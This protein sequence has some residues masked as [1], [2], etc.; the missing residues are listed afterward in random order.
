VILSARDYRRYVAFT[1]GGL[2]IFGS[3]V[4]FT[5]QK[6]RSSPSVKPQPP[7]TASKPAGV[8]TSVRLAYDLKPGQTF[9]YRITGLFR[10]NFPPFAQPGS[11]PANIKAV[12][13]YVATVKKQDDKGAEI[14]FEIDVADLSLLEKEPGPDGKIDPE[15]EIPFPIPTSQA[16]KT[17]NVTAVIRPDGSVASVTNND[18]APLRTELGIDLRKL[19][20]LILPVTFPDKPLKI[21]EEWTHNDGVLGQKPGK[22]TYHNRLLTVT[23]EAK[24]LAFRVQHDATSLIDDKKDKDG[25]LSDDPANAVETTTGKATASGTLLFLTPATS[26][27]PGTPEQRT[28][29]LQKGQFLLNASLQRT[30]PNPEKPE[31]KQISNIEVKARLTVISIP[32]VRK[33]GTTAAA[34]PAPK[35]DK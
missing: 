35:K 19:F 24:R 34:L 30:A 8:P 11:P 21:N 1:L 12:L 23:P 6:I 18:T 15:S 2:L 13:E 14:A 5:Q 9:R 33:Q 25:K 31:E 22:I 17:L 29:R 28:G 7:V 10:G 27:K 16:Q 20:L 26:A 32:N 4:A 3:G